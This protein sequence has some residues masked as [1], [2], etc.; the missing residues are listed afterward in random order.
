MKKQKLKIVHILL[1]NE[2]LQAKK[3][4][5]NLELND[6]FKDVKEIEG[7]RELYTSKLNDLYQDRMML[8]EYFSN[9]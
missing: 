9:M 8:S 4:L 7:V 2:I 5:I 1:E 3:S 6:K